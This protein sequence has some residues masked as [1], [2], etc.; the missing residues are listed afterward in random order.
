MGRS[1]GHELEVVGRGGPRDVAETWA[2]PRVVGDF[3]TFS[4]G[5]VAEN[6]LESDRPGS[7]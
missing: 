6:K 4:T 1:M 7:V 3:C 5:C 2:S